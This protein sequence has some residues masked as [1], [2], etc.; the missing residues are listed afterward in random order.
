MDLARDNL[1]VTLS[2][3]CLSPVTPILVGSLGPQ[4]LWNQSW[5]IDLNGCNTVTI[6]KA[7]TPGK[8]DTTGVDGIRL[9]GDPAP[10]SVGSYHTSD[11]REFMTGRNASVPNSVAQDGLSQRLMDGVFRFTIDQNVDSLIL[12]RHNFN[13]RDDIRI[14]TDQCTVLGHAQTGLIFDN[15]NPTG[16]WNDPIV[17]SNIRSCTRVTIQRLQSTGLTAWAAI[18]ERMDLLADPQPTLT[19]GNLYEEFSTGLSYAGFWEPVSFTDI[20]SRRIVRT[21]ALNASVTFTVTGNGFIVY[22][23][24]SSFGT[25]NVRVCVTTGLNTTNETCTNYSIQSPTPILQYPV[26][27]YGLGNGTHTVTITNNQ[28]GGNLTLDAIRIP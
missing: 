13:Y 23:R 10:L 28:S 22:H 4:P 19:S 9:L 5:T 2:N 12:Y 6:T 26:G 18:M 25:N 21:S 20:P 3:T 8:L 7:N 14:D 16:I 27:I 15:L 11:L 17:V 24:A 1:L